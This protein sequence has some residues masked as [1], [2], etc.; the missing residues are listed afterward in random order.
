MVLQSSVSGL[1]EDCLNTL[2]RK[3]QTTRFVKLHYIEA[4]M[5]AACVPAILAYKAEEL[6]A[7]LVAVI[8]EIPAGR[9]LSSMSLELL[10]KQ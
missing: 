9:D 2:A 8:E 1:V 5:D 10:L 6:I 4:E 7:N 3:H